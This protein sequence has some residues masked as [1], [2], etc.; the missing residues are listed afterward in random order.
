MKFFWNI[1][2]G[3]Y[4]IAH[5][6]KPAEQLIRPTG[7][8]DP[9]IQLKKFLELDKIEKEIKVEDLV[10]IKHIKKTQIFIQKFR[11]ESQIKNLPG[12]PN[13]AYSLPI[14]SFISQDKKTQYEFSF[15]VKVKQESC[16]AKALDGMKNDLNKNEMTCFG[17]GETRH[18]EADGSPFANEV[19]H[20]GWQGSQLFAWNGMHLIDREQ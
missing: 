20:L 13:V 1:S 6:P 16:I 4:E 19:L 9:P 15:F 10:K 7:L 2:P 12:L 8:L 18:E 11:L 14:I 17:F 3:D 5:S